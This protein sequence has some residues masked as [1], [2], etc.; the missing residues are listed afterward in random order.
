MDFLTLLRDD[1]REGLAKTS[2][3]FRAR[4]TAWIVSQQCPEGGFANRRGKIDLYYTAFALRSLSALNEL[5]P[6]IATRTSTW[7]CAIGRDADAVRLRQPHGAF[8]DTDSDTSTGEAGIGRNS[9]SEWNTVSCRCA[10]RARPLFDYH[11]P[12]IFGTRRL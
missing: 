9:T 4:H 12:L 8:C 2:P 1:I 5:T 7:L 11:G 6:A 3:E 10:W